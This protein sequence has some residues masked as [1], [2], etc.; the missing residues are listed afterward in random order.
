ML[1]Y[2]DLVSWY[3]MF[4]PP[5]EYAGEAASYRAAFDSAVTPPPR[6][7]LELGAGAGH[8]A[9]HLKQRF[10]CTLTDLSDAMLSLS[11]ELNPDCEH[12]HGDMR[13]LRLG[14]QFDVVLVHDAIAYMLSEQDLA[15][16]M[17]TAFAH[18]RPGGAA[19]F[20]PDHMTETFH[21]GTDFTTGEDGDRALRAIA[22]AWDPDPS[23]NSYTVEYAFLLR[24][25]TRVTTAHDTHVEGLFP[26]ATWVRLLTDAGFSVEMVARPVD[27]E[28]ASDEVF[29]ARRPHAA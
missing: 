29:L 2:G 15:A 10:Q 22:W 24:E 20:A 8:N 4:T 13:T 16:T 6:T 14:R 18:T 11:R 27:D 12:L 25:G 17:A 5:S 23:D 19:L 21:E 28:G 9:F 3:R 1:L 26:R 7:L